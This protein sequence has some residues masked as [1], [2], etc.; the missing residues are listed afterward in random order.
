MSRGS[1]AATHRRGDARDR[2]WRRRAGGGE[3][4]G[5]EGRDSGWQGEEVTRRVQVKGGGFREK[6]A[7]N[8]GSARRMDRTLWARR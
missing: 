6:A 7:V 8:L 1:A 5:G 3:K 2:G 4:G